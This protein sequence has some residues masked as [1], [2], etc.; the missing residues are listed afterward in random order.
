[1]E[2]S[3][4]KI[5]RILY[6]N[7]HSLRNKRIKIFSDNKNVQSV[8]E[9]GS[10]KTD[11]QSIAIDV[12]DFC[13]RENMT[14]GTQWIPREMNQEAD[15]LSKCSN[16]DDWSI[17][18][19]VFVMLDKKWGPHT[20]DRF[21]SLVTAKCIRFNSKWWVPKTEGINAFDQRWSFENN[22]LVPPPGLVAK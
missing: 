11:L 18:N 7:V 10:R 5:K 16:N 14:I 22:W 20:V 8:L 6:S 15:Y 21:A 19:W 4:G 13:K 9:I 1:M 12:F 17:Q 3:R 2:G